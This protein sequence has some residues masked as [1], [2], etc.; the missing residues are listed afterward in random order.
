ML[1]SGCGPTPVSMIATSASTR[2]SDPLMSATVERLAPTRR[3]PFGIVCAVSWMISSLMTATTL[4]SVRSARRWPASRV[5]VKPLIARVNV[6][7]ARTSARA[8]AR[9]TAVAVLTP[10]LSTTMYLPVASRPPFGAAGASGTTGSGAAG[11]SSAGVGADSTGGADGVGWT[12]G[13][14][15]AGSGVTAGVGATVG[16]TEGAGS[17]LGIGSGV[18]VALGSAALAG[19]TRVRTISV[20]SREAAGRRRMGT[21]LGRASEEHGGDGSHTPRS[22]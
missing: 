3:T 20:A 5:A 19:A 8:A 16:S 18:S 11:G 6:R 21:P 10:V 13:T 22:T 14:L 17:V 2:W 15:G 12:S 4:G 1:R 7:P 9:L